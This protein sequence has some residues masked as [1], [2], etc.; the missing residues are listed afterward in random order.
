[1]SLKGDVQKIKTL[2]EQGVNVNSGDQ[3]QWTALHRAAEKGKWPYVYLKHAIF[4]KNFLLA[5][6]VE[7]VTFLLQNGA[8]PN[9]KAIY[10]F[11]PL[12]KASEFGN[13]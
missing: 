8:N 9:A 10:D 2:I 6:H 5:G 7:T 4:K 11:K 13:L 3:E 12:H 1:M